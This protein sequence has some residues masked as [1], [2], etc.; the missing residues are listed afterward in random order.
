LMDE[1]NTMA[2]VVNAGGHAALESFH[3]AK[4]W[5]FCALELNDEEDPGEDTY[6]SYFEISEREDMDQSSR[7][8]LILHE[9]ELYQAKKKEGFKDK[10]LY[11]TMET[12]VQ[13]R[14]QLKKVDPD[15]RRRERM[16]EIRAKHREKTAG[17][18]QITESKLANTISSLRRV[19]VEKSD[20]I[21]NIDCML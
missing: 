11:K 10:G 9:A 20:A 1:L 18:L 17:S 2:L 13:T 12:M 3:S 4:N 6:S 16:M 14:Q 7:S 8:L 5:K 19:Q 15:Q 21:E